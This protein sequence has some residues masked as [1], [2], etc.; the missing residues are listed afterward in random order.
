MLRHDDCAEMVA[1]GIPDPDAF[2][3]G[4]KK[5]AAPIHLHPIWHTVALPAR[6]IAED[7]AVTESSIGAYIVDADVKD[8]FLS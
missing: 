8:V 7:A 2:G 3:A 1:V 6:L 4:D 5:I